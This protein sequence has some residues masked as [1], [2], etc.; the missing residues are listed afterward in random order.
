MESL[1]YRE[2]QELCRRNISLLPKGARCGGRGVSK[3]YLLKVLKD[4]EIAIG[5]YAPTKRLRL[6]FELF[7]WP[8]ANGEGRFSVS[9]LDDRS[10]RIID[11][12]V[13]SDSIGLHD[14]LLSYSIVDVVWSLEDNLLEVT[15][16]NPDSSLFG[17]AEKDELFN[18]ISPDGLAPDG[19]MEG[20]LDV[21]ERL[22]LPS[23]ESL[24]LIPTIVS[25]SN[26]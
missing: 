16:E 20:D 5:T 25:I 19:W 15:I 11:E 1:S 10:K 2:L 26:A 7:L 6:D 18:E 24:E 4:A 14:I 8:Q 12:M 21:S 3:Q 23:Y 17:E 22:N 13:M 9:S